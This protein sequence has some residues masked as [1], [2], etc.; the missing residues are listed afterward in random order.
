[1]KGLGF[2]PKLPLPFPFFASEH[3]V[4]PDLPA[5]ETGN[6]TQILLGGCRG[7]G[8]VL[9]VASCIPIAILRASV[10]V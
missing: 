5:L 3:S 2:F 10:L 4:A 1:M 7:V 6:V 9:I 8:M